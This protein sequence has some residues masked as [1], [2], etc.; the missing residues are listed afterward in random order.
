MLLYNKA[1][2]LFSVSMAEK[3][4][5]PFPYPLIHRGLWKPFKHIHIISVPEG[6]KREKKGIEN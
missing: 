6:E 4:G 3:T 5:A 2:I 1:D